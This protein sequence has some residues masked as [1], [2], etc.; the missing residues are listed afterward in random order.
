MMKLTFRGSLFSYG[1]LFLVLILPYWAGEDVIAPNRYFSELGI[2]DQTGI[3][4]IE[5]RKFSDYSKV[6]YTFFTEKNS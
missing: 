3:K 2:V 4:K 5:N 6:F 1:L